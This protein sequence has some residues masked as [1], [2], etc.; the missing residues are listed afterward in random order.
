MRIHLNP[1]IT[2][3]IASLVAT[4]IAVVASSAGGEE[5]EVRQPSSSCGRVVA[6]VDE[7]A[8]AEPHAEQ[9]QQRLENAPSTFDFQIVRYSRERGSPTTA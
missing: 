4:I 5:L 1:P 9:V 3:H 7:R 2:G 8:D 6:A